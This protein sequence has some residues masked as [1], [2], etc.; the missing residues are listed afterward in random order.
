MAKYVL[1]YYCKKKFDR[2][3]LPFVQVSAKRYAHTECAHD[4]AQHQSQEEK[5]REALEAYIKK[6]FNTDFVEPRTQKLIKQYRED[7]HYTY[8]GIL[9][10]LTYF[11][12]VKGNNIEKANGSIGIVPYTYKQAYDY[13]LSVWEA[14]QS[15]EGKVIENYRPE[16]KEVSIMR[17]R[18]I[19]K[20]VNWSFLDQED[21]E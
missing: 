17:P 2:D 19:K 8:S 10:A 18:R 12:D 4:A 9:K 5:D 6:L 20:L 14:N 7:Y 15:N 3:R 1:C 11:Y 13:Y 21:E 16:V